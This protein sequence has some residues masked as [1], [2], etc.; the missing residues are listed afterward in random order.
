MTHIF[1]VTNFFVIFFVGTSLKVLDFGQMT[2][3]YYLKIT[4]F[5][6]LIHSDT[7]NMCTWDI[8]WASFSFF[9][10]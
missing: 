8:S 7:Q 3:I 10:L 2:Y 9:H 1:Q 4:F 5:P 6:I